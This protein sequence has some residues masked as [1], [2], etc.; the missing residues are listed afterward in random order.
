MQQ[1]F[2]RCRINP[3]AKLDLHRG[4]VVGRKMASLGAVAVLLMAAVGCRQDMHNQPRLKPLRM[5][6]FYADKRG[7]RPVLEG[8]VARGQLKED[9]YLY[10]GKV[11]NQPGNVF[12]MPV[13]DKVLARGRERFNIYCTP[14]HSHVGD[15]NGMIVQRGLRKPPSF[16]IDRL[17]AAPAGHFFD[18]MTNGFGAMPDYAAQISV[19]DR[20]AIIAYIR[21]LQLSQ[22]AGQVIAGQ[23]VSDK[24]VAEGIDVSSIGS[25]ATLPARRTP[26]KTEGGQHE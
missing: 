12:P 17:R 23:Q 21:A 22:N 13:T 3:Q 2:R 9:T 4:V 14:C 19:E 15:G 1:I 7:S 11:N 5:S 18:V 24:P 26:V 6:D 8:T 25:G 16:H 10:T 20:W